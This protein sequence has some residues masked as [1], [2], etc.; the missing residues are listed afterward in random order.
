MLSLQKCEVAYFW[1]IVTIN[2]LQPHDEFPSRFREILE[3]L[4]IKEKTKKCKLKLIWMAWSW[5]DRVIK[6]HLKPT[7]HALDIQDCGAWIYVPLCSNRTSWK[8]D[9]KTFLELL[10]V[11]LYI[12][13]HGRHLHEFVWIHFPQPFNVNRSSFFIHPMITMR[14]VPQNFILLFEFKVLGEIASILR[15]KIFHI[16][17]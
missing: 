4:K 7:Y 15:I 9:S 11:V 6:K 12:S 2:F 13:I 1:V 10:N 8:L 16:F 14:I 3:A 5:T 17:F